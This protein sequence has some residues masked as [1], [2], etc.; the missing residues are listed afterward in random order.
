MNFNLVED[1]CKGC[2]YC[3]EVCPKKVLK[4]SDRYNSKGY[5]LPE[6]VNSDECTY[7]KKCELICPEIA[8]F[9]EKEEVET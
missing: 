4:E 2:G 8:L 3:I 5:L 9:I 1:Y 6:P 7:C